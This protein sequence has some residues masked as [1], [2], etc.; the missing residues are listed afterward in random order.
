MTETERLKELERLLEVHGVQSHYAAA[1]L[2]TELLRPWLDDGVSIDR[3]TVR[4]WRTGERSVQP[5][6]LGFLSMASVG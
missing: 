3:T 2:L 6:L 4:R 1:K 5:L